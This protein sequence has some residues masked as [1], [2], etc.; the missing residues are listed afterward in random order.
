[1]PGWFQATVTT[2]TFFRGF[3]KTWVVHVS[4]VHYVGQTSPF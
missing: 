4:C 3:A 1:L 2:D